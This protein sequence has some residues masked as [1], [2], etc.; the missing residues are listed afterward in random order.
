MAEVATISKVGFN[1]SLSLDGVLRCAHVP[2]IETVTVRGDG[3]LHATRVYIKSI[4]PRI[5]FTTLDVG[6]ALALNSAQFATKGLALSA[7]FS[8]Y[9]TQR[10]QDGGLATTGDKL[11]MA[12]G[13]IVPTRLSVRDMEAATLECAVHGRSADGTTN[14][15]SVTADQTVPVGT[16]ITACHTVGKLMVNGAQ[17]AANLIQSF[18]YDFGL[19]VEPLGGDGVLYPTRLHI[20]QVQPRLSW[21]L[22]DADAVAAIGLSGVAQGATDSL[23]YLRKFDPSGGRVATATAEHVKMSIDDG[24]WY[25]EDAGGESDGDVRVRLV[26]EPVWDAAVEPVVVS[27]AAIT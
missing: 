10:T 16:A 23:F 7:L 20:R 11:A 13:L 2:G 4:R 12:Q 17:I 27:I 19:A 25:V 8:G 26:C 15:L 18:D 3:Q 5:D 21:E 22:A 9:L 24:I 1:T 14:P 6:T